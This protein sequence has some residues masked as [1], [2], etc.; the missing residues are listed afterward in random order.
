MNIVKL[1]LSEQVYNI[2]KE[3]IL[4]GRILAGDKLINRELQE[5]FNVSSTPVRD[6]INKLYQDGLIK[7]VTKTG[8]KL[9]DFN[10]ED[11]E[12]INDFVSS[13]TSQA[14]ML[15]S[16]KGNAP[17]VVEGLYR[18]QEEM[19][20]AKDGNAYFDA[21]FRYNKAF[22]DYCGN[23]FLKET[24]KR[25]NMVR[26][27]LMRIATRTDEDKMDSVNQH[28]AITEAYAEKHYSQAKKLMEEHYQSGFER[29][30]E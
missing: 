5:R 30:G 6:A 3:D 19:E 8:A 28:K 29:V 22:F 25:Y 7:E 23:H 26:F 9:I 10:R 18:Y 14:L 16:R 4:A 21:E 17:H 13:L 15:S 2:L 12:E 11:A 20:K 27:L 24:Y 1:T